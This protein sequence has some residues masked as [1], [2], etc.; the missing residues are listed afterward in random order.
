L[1]RIGCLF[2]GEIE[3]AEGSSPSCRARAKRR[4]S[5]EGAVDEARKTLRTKRSLQA[6]RSVQTRRPRVKGGPPR[7]KVHQEVKAKAVRLPPKDIPRYERIGGRL[8]RIE[9]CIVVL[10]G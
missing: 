3:R 10:G 9:D 2:A 6:E 5:A 1:V 4:E 7:E 8:R